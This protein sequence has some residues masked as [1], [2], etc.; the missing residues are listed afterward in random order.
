MS[1]GGTFRLRVRRQ[2]ESLTGHFS[3][4]DEKLQGNRGENLRVTVHAL[5]S[6]ERNNAPRCTEM[7][8]SQHRETDWY[9]NVKRKETEYAAE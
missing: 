9:Q 7:L 4:N 8:L 3:E 1:T 2:N 5:A 6:H